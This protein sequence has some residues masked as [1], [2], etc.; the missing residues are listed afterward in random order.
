MLLPRTA[1]FL[2]VA[3]ACVLI[4]CATWAPIRHSPGGVVVHRYPGAVVVFADTFEQLDMAGQELLDAELYAVV[5]GDS[6]D[7]F[8][9]LPVTPEKTDR[10]SE[11]GAL[12]T[13][14]LFGDPDARRHDVRV[15]VQDER[16]ER[17]ESK[18]RSR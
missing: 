17:I 18:G 1:A 8:D 13:R 11:K 14:Y 6:A 12:Y 15:Y 7:V 16:V 2:P 5:V 3:L 9:D 4:G 10:V